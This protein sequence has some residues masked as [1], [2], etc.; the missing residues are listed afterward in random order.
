MSG[1]Q[2]T[3][4]IYFPT[5]EK[6]ARKKFHLI[7]LPAILVLGVMVVIFLLTVYFST[8]KYGITSG[9][10][11]GEFAG[12]ENYR[13]VSGIIGSALQNT[14]LIKIIM[15]AVC[16]GLSAA[17]CTMYKAMKKPGTILTTDR[18]SVV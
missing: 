16:G 12:L 6:P 10:F 13:S 15:L 5:E 3:D 7:F 2:D 18:K 11:G 8:K 1:I 9:L 14:L 4:K 17:L